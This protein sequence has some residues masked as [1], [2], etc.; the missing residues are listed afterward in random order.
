[1][2]DKFT[3]VDNTVTLKDF[4]NG[5]LK[6]FSNLDNV[7][8]IPSIIDGLKDSQ[9][10]AVYGMILHGNSEIK[11]AQLAGFCSLHT[12]YAHGESSMAATIVGLA[13][14]FPGANNLNLLEPIG[15]FGSILNSTSAAVRY[16]YTKPS[17]HLRNVLRIEDD[18]ILEYREEEGDKLEPINY[19]PVIP[20]WLVNGSVGIGTGHSVKILP[21]DP[22]K[23]VSLIQKMVDGVKVQ[24][25]TIEQALTPHFVGWKGTVS[26]AGDLTQWELK[27]VLEKVNTT[28]IRVT[29]LPVTYDVDKYKS[30]LI[31]LMDAG[32]VK[33]YDNNST[34]DGFDFTISVP[35]EVG[36]LDLEELEDLFKL[37]NRIGEN[38]TMWNTQGKLNKYPSVLEALQEFVEFRVGKYAIRKERQLENMNSEMSWLRA[39]VKF[40]EY[41]NSGMKDPH[42]KSKEQ[43]VKELKGVVP[44]EFI[45]RL[46]GLQIRSLTMEMVK[47][48][49]D[50][51]SALENK[52]L[53][54]EGKTESDLFVSD[55]GVI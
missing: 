4:I 41:W 31:K 33:D 15:Q 47:D 34:E 1:M 53:E 14:R 24:Q 39:R 18:T 37:K 25:R 45:D 55:L 38:I 49:K 12:Q 40:I 19:F 26:S 6:A 32:K 23:I 30:I 52:I 3:G 16:I 22:K 20:L 43:L 46:L 35:R 11:C 48:L 28:T 2:L 50:K 17:H 10:K 5:E 8:S 54:L 44:E 42:K 29:E 36:K 9:R 21:R 7:R 13:Q 27:G 51:V